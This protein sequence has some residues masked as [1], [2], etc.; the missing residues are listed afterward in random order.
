MGMNDDEGLLE[1]IDVLLSAPH[2]DECLLITLV[3]LTRV[4][5]TDKLHQTWKKHE[6]DTFCS[7]VLLVSSTKNDRFLQIVARVVRRLQKPIETQS[8]QALLAVLSSRWKDPLATLDVDLILAL[9]SSMEE[10]HVKEVLSKVWQRFYFILSG[11]EIATESCQEPPMIDADWKFVH[12]T[13]DALLMQSEEDLVNSFHNAVLILFSDCGA[14]ACTTL[15]PWYE[16]M[17]LSV[18]GDPIRI[19]SDDIVSWHGVVL[20]CTHALCAAPPEELRPTLLQHKN[21]A[22][23][24]I[25]LLQFHI[26]S[27]ESELL[28]MAWMT[29][30]SLIE[31]FGFDWTNDTTTSS[32]LEGATAMCT[33][34]RSAAGEWRI[35][36]GRLCVEMDASSSL[37]IEACGGVVSAALQYALQY[38]DDLPSPALL[39]LRSSF[40]DALHAT[41]QYLCHPAQHA[42]VQGLVGRVLASLLMEFDVWEGLPD[43]IST[44]ETVHALSVAVA[45]TEDPRNV[46]P[47]LMMVL[48]SAD[49]S[50]KT[51]ILLEQYDLLGDTLVN[52]L[53]S[54]WKNKQKQVEAPQCLLACQVAELWYSLAHPPPKATAPLRKYISQWIRSSIEK[55]Q[56]NVP[57]LASVVDCYIMLCGQDTIPSERDAI[58]IQ[59]ALEICEIH[60][61]LEG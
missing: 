16:S 43:G 30:A 51:V 46:L 7:R 10:T 27:S 61:L 2:T 4:S 25:Q 52:L 33:I 47:C 50:S 3:L 36:L 6:L 37:D 41:V 34:V 8:L 57:A 53:V 14:K 21:T 48:A 60:Q 58:V 28:S 15:P 39:H 29:L 19:P 31:V 42:N 32:T 20:Q 54:F 49:G 18:T 9:H 44:E 56:V 1:K 38:A 13:L 22:T 55:E 11:G 5:D 17:I 23:A 26:S 35:Q 59:A 45:S 12:D 24:L 40:Q